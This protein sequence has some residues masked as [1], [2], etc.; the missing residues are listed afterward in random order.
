MQSKFYKIFKKKKVI[1]GVIHFPPLLDYSEFPGLKIALGNALKDLRAFEE[2]GVDGIIIENNY[3]VPHKITVSP[4]TTEAMIFLGEE[5]KRKTKLPIGVNVLWNDF[6][7]ALLTGKRIGGKFIR[8]PVFVDKIKTDCGIITGNSRE[9]LRHQ[10][11]IKA[12]DIALFTDI[13]VKHAKL[14]NKKPVEESAAVEGSQ[15]HLPL[16]PEQQ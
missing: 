3:D 16:F 4:Q 15:H 9:V 11:E 1:I 6:K 13:Q 14:L 10:K 7:T 5:I 2:G 8:I 12:E